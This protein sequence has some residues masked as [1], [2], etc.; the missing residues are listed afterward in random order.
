VA[1]EVRPIPAGGLNDKGRA[2]LRAEGHNIKKPVT[3]HEATH[4]DERHR[5]GTISGAACAA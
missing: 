1:E 3:A 5:A 4:S 2:S